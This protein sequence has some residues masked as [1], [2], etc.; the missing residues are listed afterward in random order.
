MTSLLLSQIADWIRHA[1]QRIWNS[2]RPLSCGTEIMGMA[3]DVSRSR[4]D[5]VIENAVLRHQINILRRGKKRPRLGVTDRLKLLLGASLLPAWRQAIAIVQPDTLL[6]WHRAGFRLFWRLRSRPR[7]GSPLA[8]ETI[9]LIRDMARR[10]RLWGAERIQGE[11]LKLGIK[12]CKRTIQKYMRGVR[13]RG[14]GQ[15]WAT[16][17]RNH[18]EDIWACDFVQTYDIFFRQVYAFFIVHLASRRVV[19]VAA[20]R[21][22]T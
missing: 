4:R 8:K 20:T 3:V 14:G 1:A 21:N 22:P 10:V 13:S 19:H 11:L 16:F 15:T 6:R 17:L 7:R 5:L 12:V 2:L 9:D 18:A